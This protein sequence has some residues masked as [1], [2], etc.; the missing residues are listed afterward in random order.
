MNNEGT[1]LQTPLNPFRT[2]KLQ[3]NVTVLTIHFAQGKQLIV[4]NTFHLSPNPM[5]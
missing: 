1:I 5:I 3:K 4:G 2:Q